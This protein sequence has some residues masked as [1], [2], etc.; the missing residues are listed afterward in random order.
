MK[1][2]T[3]LLCPSCYWQSTEVELDKDDGS[4]MTDYRNHLDKIHR[5]TP[6]R[7]KREVEDK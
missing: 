3:R 5:P 6:L 2:L 1:T 7:G 4:I